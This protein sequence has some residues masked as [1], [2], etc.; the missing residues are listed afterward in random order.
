MPEEPAD[1]VGSGVTG[2][3]LAVTIASGTRDGQRQSNDD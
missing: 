2:G 1:M 3:I